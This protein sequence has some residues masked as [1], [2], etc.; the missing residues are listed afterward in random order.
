MSSTKRPLEEVDD[1]DVATCNDDNSNENDE[2]IQDYFPAIKGCRSVEEFQC[3]N[4]VEEGTYGVVY[5]AKDKRTGETVA[6]K[7]LKMEMEKEG[8]PITSLR[9]ISTLLKARHENIV[10]VR[11]VVVGTN[12]DKIYLVMDFV[13]RDLKSMM[14]SMSTAFKM[15]EI[16]S[17]LYQLISAIAHM[18]SNWIIHRDLKTSNLLISSAGVLKVGDFG[19][20]REYGS[21]LKDYTPV[22]VTLWYRAPELLLQMPKYSYPIDNWSIGCIFAELISMK[23]LFQGKSEIEQINLIFRELG[24]PSEKIWPGY[25]QLPMVKKIEF[26]NHPYNSLHNRFGKRLGTSGFDLL[27]RF[28]T[29]S[30]EKRITAED[31]FEHEFFDSIVPKIFPEQPPS[32]FLDF[33]RNRL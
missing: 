4:R 1:G 14:E 30:P 10:R 15:Q 11:E 33:T 8:F 3:I 17:L 5:R 12:M 26:T 27:N 13:D 24:T 7:R 32:S 20:A 31:A 28:L 19:L 2:V 6:L 18:H 23:P 25:E 9:E 21:P 29:Y 22:V 16:K